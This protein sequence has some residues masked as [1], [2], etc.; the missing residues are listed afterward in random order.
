M[1]SGVSPFSAQVSS[2]KEVGR[3][4]LRVYCK[5]NLLIHTSRSNRTRDWKPVSAAIWDRGNAYAPSMR[6]DVR[7]RQREFLA[8]AIHSTMSGDE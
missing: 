8:R 4:L 2:L 7:G 3:R 5:V 1:P 6:G